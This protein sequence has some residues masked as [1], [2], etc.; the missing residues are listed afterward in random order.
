MEKQCVYGLDMGFAYSVLSI[1]YNDK[2]DYLGHSI[3]L[4]VIG[5]NPNSMEISAFW[6]PFKGLTCASSGRE[7]IGQSSQ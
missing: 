2:S 7:A 6:S 4:S 5:H 1:I 3:A